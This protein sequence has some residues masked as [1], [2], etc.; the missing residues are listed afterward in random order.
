MAIL[1]PGLSLPQGIPMCSPNGAYFLVVQDDGNLVGYTSPDFRPH[2]AFWSSQSQG[3]GVA[4]FRLAMQK[5]GNLVLYDSRDTPTWSTN[6]HGSGSGRDRLVIQDDRNI[7]LY[8][9]GTT[10]RWSSATNV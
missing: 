5:D 6:T 9:D 8:R 3:K 1:L 4:P 10:A 2:N 7:V